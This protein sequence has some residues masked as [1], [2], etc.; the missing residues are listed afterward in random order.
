MNFSDWYDDFTADTQCDP[1][2]VDV[3][4]GM[5]INSP[6]LLGLPVQ[7]V[8]HLPSKAMP[9]KPLPDV[10]QQRDWV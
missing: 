7:K 8:T 3:A 2:W 4:K 10:V 9:R 1:D 6:L 5:A